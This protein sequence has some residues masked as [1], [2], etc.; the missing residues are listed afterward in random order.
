M[1]DLSRK[2]FTHLFYLV[3]L[4]Y[5]LFVGIHDTIYS[6]GLYVIILIQGVAVV[7]FLLHYFL[8]NRDGKT[9]LTWALV[10]ASVLQSLF[11]TEVYYENYK[12][13]YQIVV[14]DDLEGCVYFF[15]TNDIIEDIAVN[16]DGI[17]YLPYGGN[18]IWEVEQNGRDFPNVWNT[19]HSDEITIYNQDS[20][21]LIAYDALCLQISVD[22]NYPNKPIDYYGATLCMDEVEFHQLVSD[23]VIDEQRLRKKVWTGSG[24]GQDWKLDQEKS[25]L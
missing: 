10:I 7:T 17:G 20:T 12:P 13:T 3:T 9:S 15:S 1:K 18:V 14:P 2:Y 23:N 19:S 6:L 24:N 5:G 25:R 16:D 21:Q 4:F 8:N 11:I 22:G